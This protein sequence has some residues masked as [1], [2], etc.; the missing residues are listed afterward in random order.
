MYASMQHLPRL[1]I[2]PRKAVLFFLMTVLSE[3]FFAFVGSH[4][5]T[6]TFFSAGHFS[7]F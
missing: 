6:F 2:E 7:S 1:H 4:L 5:V 3:A